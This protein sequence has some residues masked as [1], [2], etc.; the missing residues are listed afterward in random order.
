[1]VTKEISTELIKLGNDFAIPLPVTFCEGTTLQAG[2]DLKVI[3]NDRGNLEIQVNQVAAAAEEKCQICNSS[4][5]RYQCS[6]CKTRACSNCFWEWG[7]LCN[8]CAKQ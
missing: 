8:K 1:M 6:H 2:T 7:G 4:K 5:A 3:Y